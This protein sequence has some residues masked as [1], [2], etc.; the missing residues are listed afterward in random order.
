MQGVLILIGIIVILLLILTPMKYRIRCRQGCNWMKANHPALIKGV[1]SLRIHGRCNKIVKINTPAGRIYVH[2]KKNNIDL[3]ETVP[4][5]DNMPGNWYLKCGRTR[6]LLS[7]R[8]DQ[9]VNELKI[10]R[11]QI[12]PRV[13]WN[14]E[15]ELQTTHLER[16]QVLHSDRSL[17][18]NSVVI[19]PGR[20]ADFR[21]REQL[22]FFRN[23]QL[24]VHILY[25]ETHTYARGKYPECA[26]PSG[27]LELSI[28]TLRE[29]MMRTGSNFLIGYSLG[30]LIVTSYLMKHIPP[31][32]TILVAPL[33]SYERT[34]AESL[35]SDVGMFLLQKFATGFPKF[36]TMHCVKVPKQ[37]RLNQADITSFLFPTVNDVQS[38]Q[39]RDII[40]INFLKSTMRAL[41]DLRGRSSHAKTLLILPKFDKVICSEACE[42][43]ARD[44]FTRL[45]IKKLPLDH[46]IWPC[47][48]KTDDDL[49]QEAVTSFFKLQSEDTGT[50]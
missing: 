12:S 32:K 22:Q 15:E 8:E 19:V 21:S 48:T 49:V 5:L 1:V 2:P 36:M 34:N 45:T 28:K 30:G 13:L 7:T 35:Q 24:R 29:V 6:T 26:F 27:S 44:C 14:V 20:G 38:A 31:E 39:T 46:C 11:T 18:P 17:F 23:L 47:S 37:R 40:T 50:F 42:R 41:L 10:T 25:Y 16:G 4:I 3:I 9:Y 33:L 43:V